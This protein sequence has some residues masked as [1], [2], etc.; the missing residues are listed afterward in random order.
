MLSTIVRQ[1][2]LSR[3]GRL[4][5][6]VFGS[7]R[8][9]RCGPLCHAVF[10]TMPAQP[11]L[12]GGN[13]VCRCDN[14]GTADA[15]WRQCCHRDNADISRCCLE[16]ML[17]TVNADHSRCCVPAANTLTPV[18]SSFSPPEPYHVTSRPEYLCPRTM[19][20]DKILSYIRYRLIGG[21]CR[22]IV[23]SKG[24]DTLFGIIRYRT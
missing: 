23:P 21:C 10:V 4:C 22:D 9:S 19:I 3:C 15:A 8:L 18:L 7:C 16:A 24:I 20:S 17:T 6:A 2:R 5:H 11:M 1:C 13:A 14:A 12:P